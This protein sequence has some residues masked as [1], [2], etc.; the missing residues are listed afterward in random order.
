MIWKKNKEMLKLFRYIVPI[1]ILFCSVAAVAQMDKDGNFHWNELYTSDEVLELDMSLPNKVDVSAIKNRELVKYVKLRYNPWMASLPFDTTCFPNLESLSIETSLLIDLQGLEHFTQL[2]RLA[3]IPDSTRWCRNVLQ[4][5]LPSVYSKVWNLTNLEE[6]DLSI[7]PVAVTDFSKLKNLQALKGHFVYPYIDKQIENLKSLRQV[8]RIPYLYP[9]AQLE[10]VKRNIELP[11][12]ERVLKKG[13]DGTVLEKEIK[14]IV[15]KQGKMFF[16]YS[17]PYGKD[18]LLHK[19]LYI[20]KYYSSYHLASFNVKKRIRD[21]LL[22][23]TEQRA[24]CTISDT[25][26]VIVEGVLCAGR[27]YPSS[28]Y[29]VQGL[30]IYSPKEH[31]VI[32]IRIHC[33]CE[34]DNFHFAII[35][36]ETNEIKSDEFYM[37]NDEYYSANYPGSLHNNPSRTSIGGVIESELTWKDSHYKEGYDEQGRETFQVIQKNKEQIRMGLLEKYK[38]QL[39]FACSLHSGDYLLKKYYRKNYESFLH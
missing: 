15:E 16:D 5:Q 30:C 33:H 7:A 19:Y 39:A 22:F 4:E 10:D 13:T 35:D 27:I 3:L 9:N 28:L 11:K 14:H 34:N 29:E 12:K 24:F 18:T 38:D 8:Y 23:M 26:N 20:N 1:F 31:K 37:K 6:L 36:L 32:F 21:V 2:K 25:I 17:N